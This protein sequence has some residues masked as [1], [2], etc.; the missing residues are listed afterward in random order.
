M[1][2]AV[3][4]GGTVVVLPKYLLRAV[5]TYKGPAEALYYIVHL[6]TSYTMIYGCFLPLMMVYA[7]DGGGTVVVLRRYIHRA[8]YT[9]DDDTFLTTKHRTPPPHHS[10]R[11][12]A[13]HT[14]TETPL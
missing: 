12:A 10:S 7:V 4:G 2:Y 1:V 13:A 11:P 3:H 5:S 6:S 8:I 9:N 14:G